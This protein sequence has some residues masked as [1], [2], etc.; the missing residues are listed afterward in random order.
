VLKYSLFIKNAF[1]G[2]NIQ[3]LN[4]VAHAKFLHDALAV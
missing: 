2:Y 1:L 3:Q 4:N